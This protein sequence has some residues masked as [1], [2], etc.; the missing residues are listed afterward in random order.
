LASHAHPGEKTIVY[1]FLQ[2]EIGR[3][4][5]NLIFRAT[6]EVLYGAGGDGGGTDAGGDDAV[7]SRSAK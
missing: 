3:E 2:D 7:V 1:A 5:G 6:Q 4:K